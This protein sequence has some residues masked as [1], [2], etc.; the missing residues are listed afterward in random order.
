MGKITGGSAFGRGD[1]LIDTSGAVL[2]GGVHVAVVGA[3]RSTGVETVI[4]LELSGR[5]NHS[6]ELVDHLYLMDADGAAAIISDLVGLAERADPRFLD[7][8]LNRVH[9][10]PHRGR[11]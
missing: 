4:A 5:V 2:L 6:P 9:Q 8:L 3:G 1:A 10:L 11:G 7:L